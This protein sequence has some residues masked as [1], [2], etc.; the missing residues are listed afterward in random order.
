MSKYKMIATCLLGTEGI[1]AG[2]L[3]RMEAEDVSAE[4]GRVFFSGSD[5]IIA[6]ANLCL[7]SA[8]RVMIVLGE[9]KA[10]TFDELFENT[11]KIHIEDFVGKSDAFPV[12][13]YSIN[14]KLYS[15][16]DCQKI[17]KK[18]LVERMK[19][20]HQLSWFEETGATC[21]IRFSIMKDSVTIMLD[22]SGIA[23][24]K[25]GYR[26][27]SNAAPIKE[28]LAASIIDI[29]RVRDRA[30]LYDPFCGS[31]TLLIEG[32]LKALNIAPGLHRSFLS[33]RFGFINPSAWRQE[34]ARAIDSI[35]K[36]AEFHAYGSDIDEKALELTRENAK[37]AGVEKY[38]TLKKADI[39]DFEFETERAIVVTNPP[40]GERMLELKEARELYSKM[41]QVMPPEQFKS[42]NIISPDE[43]FENF[44]GRKADKKRKL[45]NGMIKCD[46]YI[47]YK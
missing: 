39:S 8:E 47:Y 26:R 42:Y 35:I 24:H 2:E 21:Q 32:A 40:Y 44:F 20:V 4:N 31:G 33:E 11:K 43:E 36:D 17:I 34:R 38:I 22:T 29:A 7:R 6:R 14:S 37:K 9:F 15:L 5:E 3:R 16:P 46:L 30:Q 41:G 27:N 12:T 25:R 45:Y 18:A 19:S 1:V 23:L 13:G 28:T 10:Y